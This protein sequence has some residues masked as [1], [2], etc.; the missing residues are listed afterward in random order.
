[1]RG[2]AGAGYPP[3]LISCVWVFL[4]LGGVGCGGW[5]GWGVLCVCLL[6]E[7]GGGGRGGLVVGWWENGVFGLPSPDRL[8][9]S[10]RCSAWLLF[11]GALSCALLPLPLLRFV[12]GVGCPSDGRTGAGW[13]SGGELLR[14]RLGL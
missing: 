2:Y 9:P 6:G 5:F 13:A 14:C 12:A 7:R 8:V 4:L 1:M 3:P 11:L 10:S